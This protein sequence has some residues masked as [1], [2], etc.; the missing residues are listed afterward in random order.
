MSGTTT[1]S[2]D[3]SSF[4]GE[5]PG[6]TRLYDNV[7][8]QVAGV[9]ISLV[10]MQAWNAIEQFYLRSTSRRESVAWTMGQGISQLDFNP[11]DETWLVA[12]ILHVE[13]LVQP[14][15][16][17]PGTLYDML[18][19]T[20]VRSGKVLL[21][22][23]PNAFAAQMPAELWQ[24]WFDTIL[25]GVLGRLYAMPAKPWSSPPLAQEHLRIYKAGISQARDIA[26]RAWTDGAGRWSFPREQGFAMGRRKN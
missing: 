19:P 9:G 5:D 18:P 23:K 8:A 20:Y 16:V 25:S 24:Q 2:S 12:W 15:V 13:G 6:V 14:K 3:L 26:Q 22:L 17:P 11:F 21:A 1:P 4:L 7:Q 10:K